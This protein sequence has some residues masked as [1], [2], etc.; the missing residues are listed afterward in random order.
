MVMIL[1]VIVSILSNGHAVL[2]LY[3]ALFLRG[4]ISEQELN[5][6]STDNSLLGVHPEHRL[7]GIDFSTGSLGQDYLMALEQLWLP[8]G[9]ALPGVYSFW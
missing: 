5:A 4:W 7:K 9:S 3:A 6:Y 8:G 2:A 1:T